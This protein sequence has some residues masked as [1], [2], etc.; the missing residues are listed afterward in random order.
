M[1]N[2]HKL[3]LGCL[4]AG[5]MA[6]ANAASAAE[7]NVIFKIHNIVPVKDAD[8]LVTAC[9]IG[10]TFYN[11]TQVE[12]SNLSL[13]LVWKDDVVSDAIAQEERA[14]RQELNNRR[15]RNGTAA[16]SS[17]DIVLNLKL[18]PLK[19]LQQVTLKSKVNTERCFL[20][21]NEMDVNVSN[22]G[23]YAT[24]E[25]ADC[26]SLMRFVSPRT[27]EYYSDFKPISYSEQMASE[28]DKT[29]LQRQEL[30]TLYQEAVSS[31]SELGKKMTETRPSKGD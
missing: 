30:N 20:L 26:L 16:Y 25:G 14:Q 11:R 2:M 9:E 7:N 23:T 5:T 4:A 13:D 8:G 1:K 12:I 6:F 27:P 3:F 28:T 22:C 24:V 18:P 21:L 15:R 31:L 17:T 19:P 29:N 10:A